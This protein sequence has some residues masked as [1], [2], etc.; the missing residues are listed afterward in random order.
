MSI[1]GS[2]GTEYNINLTVCMN[3][4]MDWKGA[5]QYEV[6][7]TS[8]RA[9]ETRTRKLDN[10]RPDRRPATVGGGDAPVNPSLEKQPEP[11]DRKSMSSTTA[12]QEELKAH[13]V[14]LAWRDQC[15][16]Y[17]FLSP[18]ALYARPYPPDPRLHTSLTSPIFSDA[19]LSKR[20]V[21]GP[22]RMG[23]FLL[24]SYACA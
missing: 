3:Q 18:R 11:D 4:R 5:S 17:V 20:I 19:H 16:A 10:L 15:S 22:I 8:G 9:E 23:G 7:M 1:G 14:P 21:P 6:C 2:P 24:F 12:S 13:R